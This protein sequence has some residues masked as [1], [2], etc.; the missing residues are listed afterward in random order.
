MNKCTCSINSFI[1]ATTVAVV[2]AIM[3]GK[4]TYHPHC[5]I[6]DQT[7]E[8]DSTKWKNPLCILQ[9]KE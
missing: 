8:A 3:F 6:P 1:G 4:G 5:T 9:G 2:W 7:E